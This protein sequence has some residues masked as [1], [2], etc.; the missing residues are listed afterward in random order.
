M[1]TSDN[2]KTLV[3][4]AGVIAALYVGYKLYKGASDIGSAVG[5]TVGRVKDA[6]SDAA[7]SFGDSTVVGTNS[8]RTSLGGAADAGENQ[9]DAEYARLARQNG[10]ETGWF[11]D[12]LLGYQRPS[13]AEPQTDSPDALG[14]TNPYTLYDPN[15]SGAAL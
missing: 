12:T 15:T 1:M 13:W 11:G 7:T 8:I 10:P 5:E 9:S 4:G 14:T 3:I 2:A 6:I